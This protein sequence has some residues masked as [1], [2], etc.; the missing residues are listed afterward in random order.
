MGHRGREKDK[1]HASRRHPWRRLSCP[2]RPAPGRRMPHSADLAL[3]PGRSCRPLPLTGSADLRCSG[4]GGLV[5]WSVAGRMGLAK[6]PWSAEGR[7]LGTAPGL[8][9]GKIPACPLS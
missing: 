3:G 5:P 6:G 2:L 9:Y 1:G 7:P 4:T 8:L